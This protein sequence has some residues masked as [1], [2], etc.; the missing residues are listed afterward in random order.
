[1][2]W[3]TRRGFLH[4]AIAAAVAPMFLPG[5][6]KG[7]NDRI[8]L[9]VI[10][11]GKQ[12]EFHVK[13]VTSQH[14]SD[15]QITAVCDAHRQFAELG[16]KI[17]HEAY[18]QDAGGSFTGCEM[19]EDHQRMLEQ[20]GLDAVLIAT[21]DHWHAQQV[22]DAARAG[23][24][25]YIEKPLSLT[26]AE[27]G[28]MVQAVRRYDRVCQTGSMQRSYSNFRQACELVRNGYIGKIKHVIVNVGGPPRDCD[29]PKEPVPAGLNWD[30]WL[31]PAPV[32][33]F[34]SILRPPHNDTFP[35]WRD[36]RDYSGGGMTD[37]GAHHFDIAQWGLGMDG[38]APVRIIPPDGREHSSLTYI[39]A[40]GVR[41]YHK[42]H[43]GRTAN[44]VLFVGQSGEIEVNRGHLE[45]RP[46]SLKA[47]ALKPGDERLYDSADHHKDFFACMRTRRR[48]ICDVEIGASSVTVCHLGNIAYWLNRPLNW[49]PAA[50]R[51]VGDDPANRLLDRA[52]RTPWTA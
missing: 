4:R 8:N 36:Y 30:R 50:G 33:P 10:G 32:R 40:D 27:A 1:M 6:A 23:K 44:G 42:E 29:L 39:Y 48:P 38:S 25:I 7:A 46:A 47:L 26:I 18:G 28:R 12:G 2:L 34:H 3:S 15:V 31:G 13:R 43:A 9:G 52:R 21:P 41:M 11:V 24:D 35:K 45:T 17:V 37:W 5:R 16:R 49:D 14:K 20:P 51:F 19:H 22:I